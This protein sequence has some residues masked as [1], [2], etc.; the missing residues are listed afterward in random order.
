MRA[1]A[2]AKWFLVLFTWLSVNVY[3]IFRKTPFVTEENID[4]MINLVY[5]QFHFGGKKY[6]LKIRGVDTEF[7]HFAAHRAQIF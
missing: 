6:K 4:T 7:R 2:Y 3:K 1:R 5:L